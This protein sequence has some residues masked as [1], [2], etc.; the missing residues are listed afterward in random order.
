MPFDEKKVKKAV[1]KVTQK[2]VLMYGQD[3]RRKAKSLI[4]KGKENPTP[5]DRSKPGKPPH[6]PTGVYKNLVLF[7]LSQDKSNVSVGVVKFEGQ[8]KGA[9][10]LEYGGKTTLKF[11]PL[12]E[13]KARRK[14]LAEERKNRLKKL[15]K[16]KRVVKKKI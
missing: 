12:A 7:G 3:L 8:S 15:K 16:R 4:K 11:K 13:Q 10:A 14:K 2:F 9:K 5:A 6:S 1:D